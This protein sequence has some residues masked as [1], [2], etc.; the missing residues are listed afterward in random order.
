MQ[1]QQRRAFSGLVITQ[2]AVG[3]WYLTQ[4][5]VVTEIDM[6]DATAVPPRHGR[7]HRRSRAA[8]HYRVEPLQNGRHAVDDT[9]VHEVIH[10]RLYVTGQDVARRATLFPLGAR[11]L[12]RAGRG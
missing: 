9:M 12:W 4:G 3:G 7:R 1:E 11:R 6:T 8:Y 2:D 10:A 5:R